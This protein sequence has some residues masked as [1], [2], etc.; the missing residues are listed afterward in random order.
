LLDQLACDGMAILLISS[1]L[2]EVM[3]LSRRLLVMRAGRV[4]AHFERSEFNQ[5]HILRC[6]VGP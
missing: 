1:E 2:P 4:A 6:M 5:T 3:A